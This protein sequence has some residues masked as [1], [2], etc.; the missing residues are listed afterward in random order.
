M[1]VASAMKSLNDHEKSNKEIKFNCNNVIKFYQ[2]C[3]SENNSEF[4]NSILLSNLNKCNINT[5]KK[6]FTR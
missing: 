4:C 1:Y 6:L 3:M 2:K 5:D